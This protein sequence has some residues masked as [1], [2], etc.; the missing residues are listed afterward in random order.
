ME[1]APFNIAFQSTLFTPTFLVNLF[2]RRP[3]ISL[4]KRFFCFRGFM[5]SG[6]NWVGNLL[7][8]HPEISCVGELHLQSLFQTVQRD[9]RQLPVMADRRVRHVVRG[10]LQAMI[11]QILSDL[12]DPLATVIGERTP[13]TLSPLA[14][15]DADQITII[16]DG[17]DV[18]ISRIFHLYNSPEV[19]RV[20][21]RFPEMRE[22]LRKFRA[23]PWHFRDHPEELLANEYVVRESMS[24]WCQHLESDRQTIARH[25]ALKVL[26]VRY[27]DFHADV[28]AGRRRMYEF[29]GVDCGKS[30]P[31]PRSLQPALD[32]ERPNEFNRK[33]QVGDWTNYMHDTARR[34]INDE[35][36]EEL[37]RQGYVTSLEW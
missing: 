28:E 8:L 15:R 21:E 35:A 17:R 27:E 7:N 19:S 37:I 11:R 25:P 1:A 34:W 22:T 31:V 4:E 24:W 36:G 32:E 12:A 5:K 10:N 16:R 18:L 6:T 33:G 30:A 20:F 26:T 14:I 2:V 9:L 3:M 23:D 13:H 29:L